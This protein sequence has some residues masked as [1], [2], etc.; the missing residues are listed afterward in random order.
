MFHH[1][2]GFDH[3]VCWSP[4][5]NFLST[6]IDLA[7][8]QDPH[9]AGD[10]RVCLAGILDMDLTIIPYLLKMDRGYQ[11]LFLDVTAGLLL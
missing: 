6:L 7:A 4:A 5:F 10:R 8:P 1:G 2:M 9:A 11:Q 3:K